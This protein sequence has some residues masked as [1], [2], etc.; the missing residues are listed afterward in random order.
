MV[1]GMLLLAII[2]LTLHS[3]PFTYGVTQVD[4]LSVGARNCVFI[5][6]P[7][8]TKILIN[9]GSAKN[10]HWTIKPFLM[11]KGIKTIDVLWITSWHKANW[12][13]VDALA[14][15]FHIKRIYTPHA[16]RD[17]AIDVHNTP[18]ESFETGDR[19]LFDSVQATVVHAPTK[20]GSKP[21]VKDSAVCLSL[22]I[23][24]TVCVLYPDRI[25]QDF[26]LAPNTA[27]AMIGPLPLKAEVSSRIPLGVISGDNVQPYNVELYKERI[28]PARDGCLSVK[29]DQRGR[30]EWSLWGSEQVFAR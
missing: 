6:T 11:A 30:T 5:Q 26:L 14:D 3:V 27:I 23:N 21:R 18:V 4:F 28:C 25:D 19:L 7:N 24:D 29:I 16:T 2:F 9:T 20:K 17:H 15:N 22:M 12:G 1:I 10:V 13:G 8:Q